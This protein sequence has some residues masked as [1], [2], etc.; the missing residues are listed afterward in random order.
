M[1]FVVSER[2]SVFLC[3]WLHIVCSFALVCASRWMT[4]VCGCVCVCQTA[5]KFCTQANNLQ[6]GVD[7]D[8]KPAD[9]RA[10]SVADP[11]FPSSECLL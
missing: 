2:E 10:T 11:L 4:C 8:D 9:A 7:E 5:A 6:D 1:L 3:K